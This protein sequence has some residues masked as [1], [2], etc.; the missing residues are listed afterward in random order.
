MTVLDINEDE[1]RELLAG[2][3]EAEKAALHE[4][5]APEEDDC[6]WIHIRGPLRDQARALQLLQTVM[7]ELPAVSV[8][9]GTIRAQD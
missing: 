1:L 3:A 7:W 9:L 8:G 6:F 4:I 5:Q 2:E